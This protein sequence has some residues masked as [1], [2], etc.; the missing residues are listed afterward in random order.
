VA[1]SLRD[2]TDDVTLI[3]S[4]LVGNAVQ[5]AHSPVDVALIAAGDILVILVAD[6]SRLLPVI[7]PAADYSESGHGLIIVDAIADRW[8]H[9]ASNAGKTVWASLRFA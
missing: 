7:G 3:A 1:A 5:H 8:G 4:E 6:S 2:L 9:W